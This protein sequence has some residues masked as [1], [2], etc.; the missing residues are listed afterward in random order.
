MAKD[1]KVAEVA[2]DEAAK[3]DAAAAAAAESNAAFVQSVDPIMVMKSF[4]C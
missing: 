1:A 2:K 4:L 3:D